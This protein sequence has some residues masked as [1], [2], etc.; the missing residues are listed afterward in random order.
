LEARNL[1]AWPVVLDLGECLSVAWV[2][3]EESDQAVCQECPWEVA[4]AQVVTLTLTMWISHKSKPHPSSP[5]LSSINQKKR[6]LLIKKLWEP[7]KVVLK[8]LKLTRTMPLLV[9]E[10]KLG[11]GRLLNMR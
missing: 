2:R 9:A 11:L 4:Q 7:K 10:R 5:S 3:W 1:E 6:K 8:L